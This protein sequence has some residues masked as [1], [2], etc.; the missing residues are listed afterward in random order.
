MNQ[1]RAVV[2][3]PTASG[4][5]AVR[6]VA[7]PSAGG[8]EAM[9]RVRAI[10]LNLGEIRR[11]RAAQAGWRPGWD[12]AGVVEAAAADGSGPKAGARVVGFL[13][14]AAWA[15]LLA[16]PTGSL[17][18]I[19]DS[20][21]FEAAATLPVAGMTALYALGKNGSLLGRPVLITGA[22][23]GVGQFAVQLAQ[24]SGARVVACVSRAERAKY[25]R[26]CG[27]DEVL[28]GNDPEGASRFG[29]YHLILESIGGKSLAA[30]LSMLRPAGMCV[31]FGTSDT[32][33]V[34]FDARQ[35]YS[36]AGILYGFILFDEVKRESAAQGLAR[37]V[38]LMAAGRLRSPIE[39]RGSWNEIG[40][41]AERLWNRE[42]AGKVVL[43][44]D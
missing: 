23:G 38:S 22:S 3:D 24:L 42:I 9:I 39:V 27:A 8:S 26:D 4:R 17:A 37:L 29:P 43:S 30:A 19:P 31:L 44:I 7:A 41:F 16:I 11:A 20:I 1:I 10:S 34:T 21:S 40:K 6:N 15:E 5:L 35:F 18:A 36:G 28:V 25:A 2:V 13:P 12:V 32:P 14:V 33:E